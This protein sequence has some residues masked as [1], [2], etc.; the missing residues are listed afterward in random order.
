M[1]ASSTDFVTAPRSVAVWAMSL[2]SSSSKC[3]EEARGDLL[4]HREQKRGNL[5]GAGQDLVLLLLI[6]AYSAFG[7]HL[8]LGR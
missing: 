4:V 2:M 1:R 6:S 7:L 8:G 3:F 5:L